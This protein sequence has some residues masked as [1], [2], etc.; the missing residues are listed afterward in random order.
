MNLRICRKTQFKY[1][2]EVAFFKLDILVDYEL[3]TYKL[4]ILNGM[5]LRI[6]RKTQF[7]YDSKVA[8][9]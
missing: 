4:I 3:I 2:F 7:K 6:C 5:N 8:F 1:D 9:F